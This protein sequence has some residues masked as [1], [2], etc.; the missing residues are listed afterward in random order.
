MNMVDNAI[1]RSENVDAV[2][3]RTYQYINVDGNYNGW[4]YI[5]Y[6]RQFNKIN[7]DAGLYLSLIHI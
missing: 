4:G 5:S 1:S 7:F 3:R 6:G 2:G